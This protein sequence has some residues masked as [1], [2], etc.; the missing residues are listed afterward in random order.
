MSGTRFDPAREARIMER[1]E[2]LAHEIIGELGTS[3]GDHH[4]DIDN[5]EGMNRGVGGTAS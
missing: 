2:R 3:G 5:L 1:C 4:E